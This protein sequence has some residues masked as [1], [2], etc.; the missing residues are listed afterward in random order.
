[1]IF[2]GTKEFSRSIH[3]GRV[4]TNNAIKDKIDSQDKN[5]DT[6]GISTREETH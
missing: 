5:L 3:L 4:E 2:I 6:K 1:M